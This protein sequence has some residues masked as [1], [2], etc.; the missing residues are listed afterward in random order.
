MYQDLI[1]LINHDNEEINAREGRY[2]SRKIDRQADIQ[3]DRHNPINRYRHSNRQMKQ[4]REM[5]TETVKKM[6]RERSSIRERMHSN[7]WR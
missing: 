1:I 4:R 6:K 7:S 5:E 3:L 2:K